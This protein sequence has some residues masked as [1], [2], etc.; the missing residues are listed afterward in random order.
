[1][2]FPGSAVDTMDGQN[3]HREYRAHIL[4]KTLFIVFS[5]LAVVALAL[6]SLTL[7]AS[8]I[9][10]S[11]II[12]IIRDTLDGVNYEA[13]SHRWLDQ[14]TIIDIRMPRVIFAIVCGGSLAVGGTAMQSVMR[15][16]LADPFTTGVSSAAMFGGAVAM[17]LGLS[18]ASGYGD[19]YGVAMN[20]LIF[21]MIPVI[22]ILFLSP[23]T[24]KSPATLILA[25]VAISFF[26]SALRTM[27]MV[28]TDEETLAT[29]YHWQ[30]GSLD[31]LKWS[32][33]P[34]PMA[35]T[36]VGTTLLIAISNKLNILSTSDEDARSLGVDP[37]TL[38]I[39][40][41]VILSAMTATVVI[42]VGVI[43]FVGLV[44]PHIVRL[45]IGSDN[46]FVIPGSF[47]FGAAFL[48]FC[49]VVSRHISDIGTVPVGI[50]VSFIGGALFL[51]LLFK[52]R[53]KVW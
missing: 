29:V 21:S 39:V 38:R 3:R 26:F 6:Y 37:E 11:E 15:N 27:L 4:K 36:I 25:G 53:S 24:K 17:I 47:F 23:Y 42:F 40:A 31:D 43:G 44:I 13:Y 9:P 5:F 49:D 2:K 33:L 12:E 18:I 8:D 46:R 41:L 52:Q 50:V 16:P 45:V 34:L 30:I 19:Q 7:G 48:L 14:G 35:T 22:L 28:M 51:V 10:V 32:Y 1:V 20:A